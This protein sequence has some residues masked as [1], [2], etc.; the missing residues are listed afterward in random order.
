MVAAQVLSVLTQIPLEWNGMSSPVGH[1]G[2]AVE[3]IHDF[4][5]IGIIELNN[6]ISFWVVWDAISIRHV[7]TSVVPKS[8]SALIEKL[9]TS[10]L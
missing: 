3:A 7:H 1:F 6:M 2:I 9:P 5:V 10:A 8:P 4:L